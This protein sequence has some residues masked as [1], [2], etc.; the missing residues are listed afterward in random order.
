MIMMMM[1]IIIIIICLFSW[2]IR[3]VG[4]VACV[5][6]M[7]KITE[8]GEKTWSEDHLDFLSMGDCIL[9]KTGEVSIT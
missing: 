2:W 8:F 3:W 1:I 6:E 4:S 9:Y 7:R 5:G